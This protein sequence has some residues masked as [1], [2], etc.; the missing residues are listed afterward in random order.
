ML[1]EFK[2]DYNAMEAAKNI[3]VLSECEVDNSTVKPDGSRILFL[4]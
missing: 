2:L 4:L 1:H 3:G